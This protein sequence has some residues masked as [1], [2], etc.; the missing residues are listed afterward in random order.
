MR[1]C[2]LLSLVALLVVALVA[3]VLITPT[4]TMAATPSLRGSSLPSIN[5]KGRAVA[6]NNDTHYFVLSFTCSDGALR[7]GWTY[8][9]SSTQ[10]F[11]GMVGSASCALVPANGGSSTSPDG[12]HVGPLTNIPLMYQ[13]NNV[14]TLTLFLANIVAS[15]TFF[16]NTTV[17]CSTTSSPCIEVDT[18]L[19]LGSPINLAGFSSQCARPP[20]PPDVICTNLF[21]T[22]NLS[23]Q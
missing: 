13:G 14:G 22:L 18:S 19:M 20:T 4:R 21:A 11:T 23:G 10:S 1:R 17:D 5:F 2:S 16:P 9:F 15:K 3:A 12:T 7:A 8:E 6:K